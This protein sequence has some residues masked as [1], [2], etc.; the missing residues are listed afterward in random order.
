[1]EGLPEGMRAAIEKGNVFTDCVVVASNDYHWFLIEPGKPAFYDIVMPKEFVPDEMELEVGEKL[2]V[3]VVEIQIADDGK[4]GVFVK[5][6]LEPD[7][8]LSED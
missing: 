1:M 3:Q 6:V 4:P 7:G 2:D 5:P 8:Q